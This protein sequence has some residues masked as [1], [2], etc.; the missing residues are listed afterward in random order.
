MMRRPDGTR[1]TEQRGKAGEP[2]SQRVAGFSL[3]ELLIVVILVAMLGRIAVSRYG[4]SIVHHELTAAAR[5]VQADLTLGRQQAMTAGANK[6]VQFTPGTGRYSLPGLTD[7]NRPGQS[8]AVDLGP[9]PYQVTI[10]SANLDGA[11]ATT[12]TFDAFGRPVYAQ[13][14]ASGVVPSIVL[15]AGGRTKT[16]AV[17]PTSGRAYLP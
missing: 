10:S 12:I 7:L 17:D 11:G 2:R 4:G 14:P 13:P 15:S 8:Y 9:A 1:Q 6:S 16:V 5:R 3:V